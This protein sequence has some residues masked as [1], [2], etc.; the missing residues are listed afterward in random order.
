MASLLAGNHLVTLGNALPTLLLPI[1]VAS[2]VSVTENAYFYMTWLVGGIFFMISSAVGSSLFAE[3]SHRPENVRAQ[4][5]SSAR[6][7]ATLLAPAMV[8]IFITGGWI[9]R[10]FGAEYAN[11]GRDL[12]LILTLSAV[13][14]AITNLYV[15]VLRVRRRLRAAAGL[16]TGMAFVAVAGAWLMAP[17]HGLTGVG[18]AWIV[19]QVVGSLWVGWD[20]WAER[21][22]ARAR[23]LVVGSPQAGGN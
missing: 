2:R 4:F 23:R 21:R 12:L 13:P 7:T 1:V 22:G 11:H 9:L 20:A 5:L 14:D 6:L 19:S 15:A 16:A 10:L 18:V 17:R 3:G 8:F